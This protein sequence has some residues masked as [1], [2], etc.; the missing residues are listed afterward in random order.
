MKV[1]SA[2][3]RTDIPAFYS[4]W[5]LNRIRAGFC[6][7]INP[8]NSQQ[9]LE[10]SLRPEDCLALVFWTRNPRPL[11][12]HLDA[13]QD[14]RY[15]FHF[16][17]NGYPREIES[18]SPTLDDAVASFRDLS[19]AVGSDRVFW[20]YDPIVLSEGLAPVCHHLDRF[21]YLA[22]QLTGLTRRCYFSFVDRYGKTERN[23]ARVE[24]V[25]GARFRE[26][27]SEER[28]ELVGRMREVAS[29]YGIQLY[30]CCGDDLLKAGVHKAS[31]I[32]LGLI[33]TL[34]ARQSLKL[35]KA[36]T[37]TDCGCVEAVDIGAYDSCAFGC[38][39][40]YAT[41]SRDVALRRMRAHNPGDTA[42]WR[43]A[44]LDGIDLGSLV[45]QDT[46]LGKPPRGQGPAQT[47]MFGDS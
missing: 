3:R 5:F 32:D 31:C 12:G 18:N 34:C 11:L 15:Y 23:L 26:P 43:P 21:E 17:I 46:A 19:A 13:L 14:H 30:S 16:T 7:W 4:K 24:R 10:V 6:H 9:V 47:A 20:R 36:P 38:T 39:Y 29:E 2:S 25:T 22:R 27:S 35:K 45:K 28:L 8:F 44:S 33:Q 42:L 41:N 1:I 40:C 37:R